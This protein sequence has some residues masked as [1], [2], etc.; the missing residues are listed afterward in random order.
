MKRLVLGIAV[1]CVAAIA[2]AQPKGNSVRL[3]VPLNM[4]TNT[5][6]VAVD[7]DQP[8]GTQSTPDTGVLDVQLP[9]LI[10]DAGETVVLT[11]HLHTRGG[12]DLD[13]GDM[14]V[15]DQVV[16]GVMDRDQKQK[17]RRHGQRK[18]KGQH[19][20]VLDNSPGEHRLV[21]SAN[22]LDKHGTSVHRAAAASYTVATG[23]L[24]FL[25]VGSVHPVG[26]LLVVEIKVR[27]PQ[28]GSFGISATIASGPIAVARA[29][30]WADLKPG[31]SIIELPF[32]QAN[33][34]EAGPYRL[35]DVTATGGASE[36]GP[37]IVAVR[38]TLGRPFQ[39]AHA[40]HEPEPS[41]NEEGAYVG[42]GPVSPAADPNAQ[43][44]PPPEPAPV[45]IPDWP[46]GEPVWSDGSPRHRAPQAP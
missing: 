42:I 16:L 15:D 14:D 19:A 10:Y 23:E 6:S 39:A 36:G 31:V 28:G 44:P 40:D 25:D 9:K 20:V 43:P 2:G 29:D 41:R 22:A 33:I 35:V 17:P 13:G 24:Q 30:T 11:T 7:G 27:A 4:P 26:N 34:V 5:V 46:E 37:A 18:G 8:P 1:V 3:G 21:V 45:V 38:D 12:A 32:A